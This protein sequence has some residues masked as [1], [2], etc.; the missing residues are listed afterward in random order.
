MKRLGVMLAIAASVSGCAWLTNFAKE[1]KPKVLMKRV[2]IAGV[3]F[4][5]ARM[6]AEL[7][8]T[9][10]LPVAIQLARIDWKVTIDELQLVTGQITDAMSLPPA[11]AVPVKIPFALKFDE[12]YRIAEKYR[13][14]DQAPYK[15]TGT[16]HIDNPTG[17]PF[18]VPF[19]QAGTFPVLKVPQVEL[20]K[21]ELKGLSFT[22]ADVRLALNVKNP[23]GQ[24]LNLQSLD[25]TL[26][27]AGA[28]VATGNLPSALEL[29][30]KGEG[31]FGTDIKVSFS[32][33]AAAMEAIKRASNADYSIG[34]NLSART[35]WGQVA[36]PFTKSGTVRIQK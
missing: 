28:Q 1:N 18:Q 8:V 22:S 10:Q 33:A 11:T 24:A 20:S 21:V 17:Q 34:G 29:P 36:T 30:A 6:E 35:P 19:S 31:H 13:D 26:T 16:L 5:Q 4:Q 32:Q 27:L 15:L 23:N 9:N 3:D 2:S 12:V 14:Q 7:A 25:Y